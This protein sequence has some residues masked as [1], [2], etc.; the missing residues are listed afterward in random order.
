MDVLVQPGLE[1]RGVAPGQEHTFTIE[2]VARGA[3][4]YT[5]D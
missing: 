3:G 5:T 1:G 4:T 2:L